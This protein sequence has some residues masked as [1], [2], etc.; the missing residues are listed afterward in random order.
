[1]SISVE[2]DFDRCT[3]IE[4]HPQVTVSNVG[5]AQKSSPRVKILMAREFPA[6]SYVVILDGD[7]AGRHSL[8]EQGALSSFLAMYTT[9]MFQNSYGPGPEVQPHTN[10][11]N[12]K[13]SSH[14]LPGHS[15][16]SHI[17]L[18]TVLVQQHAYSVNGS[19]QQQVFVRCDIVV[20]SRA[21]NVWRSDDM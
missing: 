5:T 20:G 3:V 19:S 18:H 11:G 9:A 8:G 7:S 15:G 4:D 2:P 14:Q 10:V 1:M 21:L 12:I 6:S 17:H 16:G 13:V